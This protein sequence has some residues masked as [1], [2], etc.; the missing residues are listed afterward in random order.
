MAT[1]I[2]TPKNTNDQHLRSPAQ[3]AATRKAHAVRNI[4]CMQSQLAPLKGY[5]TPAMLERLRTV[6]VSVEAQVR[7]TPAN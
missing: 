1:V 2:A 4:C 7:A 3:Q 6:L 5:V